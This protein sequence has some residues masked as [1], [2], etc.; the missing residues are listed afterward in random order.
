MILK[1]DRTFHIEIHMI[2]FKENVIYFLECLLNFRISLFH[3]TNKIIL[4]DKP[5]K[6]MDL[7]THFE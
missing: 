1:K 3:L 7:K 6:S 2:N 5:H 4:N